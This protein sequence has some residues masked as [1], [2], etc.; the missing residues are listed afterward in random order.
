MKV[1]VNRA[2]KWVMADKVLGVEDFHPAHR[3]HI[4]DVKAHIAEHED[5][6]DAPMPDDQALLDYMLDAIGNDY[7]VG[8]MNEHIAENLGELF[9]EIY[10]AKLKENQ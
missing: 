9:P 3:W 2:M 5:Y 1:N 7:F 4:D 8:Q 6:K 10:E